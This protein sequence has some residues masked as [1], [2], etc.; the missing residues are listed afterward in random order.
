MSE[1]IVT[2]RRSSGR[3]EQGA[4]SLESPNSHGMRFTTPLT[5]E[6]EGV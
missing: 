6:S 5:S 1:A 4:I 3:K 2:G